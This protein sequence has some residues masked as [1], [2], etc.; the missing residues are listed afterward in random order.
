MKTY[1]NRIIRWFIAT[2]LVLTCTAPCMGQSSGR[3]YVVLAAVADYP[4]D[5]NDLML[6]VKDAKDVK[7]LFEKNGVTRSVL[8]KNEEV[9]IAN[10]QRTLEEEFKD[11]RQD[12]TVIL[13]LSGHGV[14]GSYVAYDGMLKYPLIARA[15][16]HCKAKRKIILADACHSGTFRTTRRTKKESVSNVLIFLSSRSGEV[17]GEYAFKGNGVFT[18]SLLKGLRGK[19][20]ANRDR[21]ITAKELFK[22]VSNDVSHNT[23]GK[24]HPVMWGNFD[25]NMVIIKW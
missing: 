18:Y 9:T 19:A 21:Q 16:S 8:L 5:K 20:D 6:P 4:G 24:Q 14:E 10:L 11:A 17:S 13:Y 15:L 3:T 23:T 22:Y 1:H 25:D 2:C 7:A 12:D